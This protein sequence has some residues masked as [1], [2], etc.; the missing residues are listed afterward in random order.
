MQLDIE[1][2]PIMQRGNLIIDQ[3][4]YTVTI[5]KKVIYLQDKEMKLL[6]LLAEHPGWV[7][8]KEQI[9]EVIYN[10]GYEI[11]ENVN[12]EN[13]IYCLIRNL[14]KKLEENSYQTKYIQTIYGVGYRF[15]VPEE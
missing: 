14:R 9:Y 3:Q 11:I 6:C 4:C 10:S 1:R 8:T 7:F 12:I 15:I 13:C 2:I 5:G